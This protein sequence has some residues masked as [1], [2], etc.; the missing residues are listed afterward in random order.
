MRARAYPFSAKLNDVHMKIHLTKYICGIEEAL[1]LQQTHKGLHTH[2]AAQWLLS[3]GFLPHK[4]WSTFMRRLRSLQGQQILTTQSRGDNIAAKSNLLIFHSYLA[5]KLND[6]SPAAPVTQGEGGLVE[7]TL[8][9][10]TCQCPPPMV[11]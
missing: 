1:Q 5:Q 6:F 7:N 3:L 10:A 8:N 2:F 11:D 4:T 9:E